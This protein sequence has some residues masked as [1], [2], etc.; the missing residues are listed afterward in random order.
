[1]KADKWIW[2]PHAGHLCVGNDCR[3]HLNTCVGDY[4]VSTVGEYWPDSQVREITAESRGVVLKG[5]G[6]MRAADYREKIG[7]ETIGY[8]RLYETMVFRAGPG[9]SENKCC[10]Y[11][12]SNFR[13]LD[14]A[15]YNDPEEAFKGHMAMCEKWSEIPVSAEVDK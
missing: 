11:R 2:M 9:E 15:G 1:M 13:E 14:F 10:P 12:A 7:F 6:D 5:M 8:N 3:F 4:I